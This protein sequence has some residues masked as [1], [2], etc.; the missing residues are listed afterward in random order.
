MLRQRE[1]PL[2][3]MQGGP[4]DD[5]ERHTPYPD[6]QRRCE[7]RPAHQP[8]WRTNHKCTKCRHC[9]SGEKPEFQRFVLTAQ[10]PGNAASQNG[11]RRQKCDTPGFSIAEQGNRH[12]AAAERNDRHD[13]RQ[14]GGERPSGRADLQ[15]IEQHS[16][17]PGYPQAVVSSRSSRSP[18]ALHAHQ[19]ARGSD[20]HASHR[21]RQSRSL[22]RQL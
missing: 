5:P 1:Q 22:P 10:Q 14:H 12:P 9:H 15:I 4:C 21:L 6:Q 11:Y 3:R 19:W 13:Q 2:A 7:Q 18:P 20:R 8:G 17:P 16:Q